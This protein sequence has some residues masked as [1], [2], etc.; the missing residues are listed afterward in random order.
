MTE[1][2]TKVD[3]V[4]AAAEVFKS[5]SQKFSTA[6]THV[7]NHLPKFVYFVYVLWEYFSSILGPLLNLSRYKSQI[8]QC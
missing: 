3:S 1:R 8:T 4:Q 2:R 5:N 6:E 7:S